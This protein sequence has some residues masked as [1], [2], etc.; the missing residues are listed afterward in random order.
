MTLVTEE[1]HCWS[2]GQPPAA[3]EALGWIVRSDQVEGGWSWSAWGPRGTE[4]GRARSE[5]AA[6]VSAAQAYE[7][8]RRPVLRGM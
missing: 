4:R 1:F 8:V 2:N 3:G 7:R 6:R 5:A